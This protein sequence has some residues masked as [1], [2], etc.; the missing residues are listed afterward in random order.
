[1]LF[2]STHIHTHMHIHIY[3]NTHTH[4]NTHAHTHTHTHTYI[5]A[6]FL[7]SKLLV[8]D[9]TVLK[10]ILF[11]Y[12]HRQIISEWCNSTTTH[13]TTHCNNTLQQHTATTHCNNSLSSILTGKLLVND[14]TVLKLIRLN[15]FAIG[16]PP[17]YIRA[18][19]YRYIW[20]INVCTMTH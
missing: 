19:L 10:L 17:K 9:A 4:T 8:N 7:T 5:R 13:A 16:R 18:Q 20:L 2:A 3:T 11:I 15:P 1:M 14:A 6:H 12:F